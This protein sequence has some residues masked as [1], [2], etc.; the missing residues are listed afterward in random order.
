MCQ[1]EKSKLTHEVLLFCA[2]TVL[3]DTWMWSIKELWKRWSA[4]A[5][6]Q[7][8]IK[9]KDGF[10]PWSWPTDLVDWALFQL[11]MKWSVH[12]LCVS[13]H[14]HVHVVL[15]LSPLHTKQSLIFAKLPE[16][17]PTYLTLHQYEMVSNV[18]D[19]SLGAFKGDLCQKFTKSLPHFHF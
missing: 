15:V 12:S 10:S 18:Y 8:T 5:T 16:D 9:C 11:E 6:Q 13:Q 7:K 3:Q 4:W 17:F 14:G 2:N 19:L 1:F